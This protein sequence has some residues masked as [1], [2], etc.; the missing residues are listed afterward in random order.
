MFSRQVCSPWPGP[1]QRSDRWHQWTRSEVSSSS[2]PAA[3]KNLPYLRKSSQPT[4]ESSSIQTAEP[5]V[6]FH[7]ILEMGSHDESAHTFGSS[8]WFL[9]VPQKVLKKKLFMA[10]FSSEFYH[11]TCATIA[12]TSQMRAGAPGTL[13]WPSQNLVTTVRYEDNFQI[14]SNYN[15]F[16]K[17]AD[18][19]GGG[20]E[21]RQDMV[22]HCLLGLRSC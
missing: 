7:T 4:L 1:A 6:K 22:P 10:F 2:S 5:I 12:L 17:T 21:T 14:N 18:V 8:L 15:F 16:R 20:D 13:S 9:E 3:P 19:G 11:Q